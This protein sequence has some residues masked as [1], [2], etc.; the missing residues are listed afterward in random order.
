MFSDDEW[1][2][3]A[4]N[5]DYSDQPAWAA[6]P[7][8]SIFNQVLEQVILGEASQEFSSQCAQCTSSSIPKY[9]KAV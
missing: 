5:P 7:A 8:G 1:L 2:G 4:E 6:D 3:I 9:E